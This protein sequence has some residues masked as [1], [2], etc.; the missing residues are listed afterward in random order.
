M[1]EVVAAI[2]EVCA[3]ASESEPYQWNVGCFATTS[4]EPSSI[5]CFTSFKVT[6]ALH[7][8]T[9]VFTAGLKARVIVSLAEA[10]VMSSPQGLSIL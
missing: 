2:S 5:S 3:C 1:I 10:W 7:T 9:V 6:D 4:G 8:L